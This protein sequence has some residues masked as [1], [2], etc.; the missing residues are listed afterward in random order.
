M[1]RWGPVR[2]SRVALYDMLEMIMEVTCGR[3][4]LKERTLYPIATRTPI[5]GGYDG[6]VRGRGGVVGGQD[7]M[8]ERATQSVA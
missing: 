3:G 7:H 5:K 2:P 6:L 1:L 8:T 4:L